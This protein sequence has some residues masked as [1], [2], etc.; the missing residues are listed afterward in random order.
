MAL[1]VKIH[2]FKNP[3][4]PEIV[5]QPFI[6]FKK[7]T[8]LSKMTKEI[9]DEGVGAVEDLDEKKTD[10]LLELIFEMFDRKVSKEDLF[11]YADIS[12]LFQ[13]FLEIGSM[14]EKFSQK[15]KHPALKK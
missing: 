14:S 1:Q 2:L 8:T 13:C 3:A 4:E 7:L 15:G 5:V 6:S 11:D 9:V 10:I 12:E